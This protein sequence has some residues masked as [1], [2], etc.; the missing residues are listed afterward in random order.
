MPQKRE[1]S[2]ASR[3]VNSI[4]I[5]GT[6]YRLQKPASF[7]SWYHETPADFVFAIKATNFITHRRRLKDCAQPLA[8]FTASGLLCLKE[9]LGP[10]L[11][12]FPPE[13]PYVDDR[14]VSFAALLPHSGAAASALAK[15]HDA[16]VE[17]RAFTEAEPAIKLRH[18]FEFRHKSF[19]DPELVAALAE[20]NVAV[21][22]GNDGAHDP[23]ITTVTADHVYARMHGQTEEFVEDG[24]TDAA[25][26]T[27][28][29]R[30]EGWEKAG[31]DVFVYFDNDAKA[32]APRDAGRLAKLLGITPVL[33]PG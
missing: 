16:F 3:Q 12:Q 32:H 14:F 6:F 26:A 7:Q 1:L 10:I 17:G 8:N 5:N 9:K 15:Q 21:V 28:A 33:E 29:K 25:L 31:K 30:I 22:F 27:M 11:W 13:L 19:N 23:G 2:F 24:Y 20:H 4:E 18:A